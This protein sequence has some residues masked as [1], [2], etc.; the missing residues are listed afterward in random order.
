MPISKIIQQRFTKGLTLVEVLVSI[1]IFTLIIGAMTTIFLSS[2]KSNKIVWEQLETQ[3]EGRFVT[4]TIARELR[5]AAVSSIGG[6]PLAEASSTEII[7]YA[8]IDDDVYRER[9]RYFLTGTTL[10]KGVIKPSGSPLVYSSASE[11]FT[12]MAHDV[13][14]GADPI[15][16]Y[17]DENFTGSE[18]PLAQPVNVTSVRS[19]R[20]ALEMEEDPHASPVPFHIET[21]VEIRNLKSN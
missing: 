21:K 14:N 15:F 10:R 2:L 12:D 20:I 19:V 3:N 1:G 16:S 8:N 11:V 5:E 18:N 7:F 13:A 4:Q 6:Y 17:Y 9:V